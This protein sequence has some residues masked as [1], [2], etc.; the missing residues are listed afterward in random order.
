MLLKWKFLEISNQK[1]IS[2]KKKIHHI[3]K[4]YIKKIDGLSIISEPPYSK[5]NF[6]INLLEVDKK[7]KLSKTSLLKKLISQNIEARSVWYPNHLQKPYKN[8]QTYKIK[9][10]N[11]IF[12]N[13]I[14]LPS[15]SFLKRN[16]IKFI[17]DI[18][19]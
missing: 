8:N 19:K 2:L 1:I 7:Y 10:A 5:S 13:Y 18:L 15:S 11:K 4:E 16:Q 6:W 9:M 3:Y 17:V 14:C 12:K